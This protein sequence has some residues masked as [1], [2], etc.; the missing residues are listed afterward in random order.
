MLTPPL[1]VLVRCPQ[2]RDRAASASVGV[3]M[4]SAM[5]LNLIVVAVADVAIPLALHGSGS[6]RKERAF[7]SRRDQLEAFSLVPGLATLC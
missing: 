3:V 1:V 6:P 5:V 4:S 7:N 2:S